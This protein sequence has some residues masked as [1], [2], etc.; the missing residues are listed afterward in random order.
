MRRPLR[1]RG[2][3]GTKV[4]EKQKEKKQEKAGKEDN[5]YS[6]ELNDAELEFLQDALLLIKGVISAPQTKRYIRD[7]YQG[8]VEKLRTMRQERKIIIV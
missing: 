8:L 1:K 7:I 3:K 5:R 2:K 4:I 6:L